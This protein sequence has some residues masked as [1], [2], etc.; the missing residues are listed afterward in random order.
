[1]NWKDLFKKKDNYKMNTT[2][3]GMVTANLPTAA[4]TSGSQNYNVNMLPSTAAAQSQ[5]QSAYAPNIIGAAAVAANGVS[6]GQV[7][8]LGGQMGP[9]Q[10]ANVTS[11][12]GG[13]TF[14]INNPSQIGRAHV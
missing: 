6:S 4:A 7:L 8:T 2:S 1:M 10:W 12:G 9:V 11:G 5:F 13:G 3:K 14:T